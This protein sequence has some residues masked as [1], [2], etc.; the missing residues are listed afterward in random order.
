MKTSEECAEALGI[1]SWFDYQEECFATWEKEM[2]NTMCVYY[3][4]GKGKTETMLTCIAMRG[5][6]TC[7][8][9]APPI[10]HPRWVEVGAKLGIVVT[11]MSHAKFRQAE[12]KVSRFLPIIIDEFHLLGGHTGKG[13][14]KADRMAAGMQAPLIIGSATPN[15]ND[16]ERVYCIAHLLDPYSHR[17]GYLSWLFKNC[18]VEPNRFGSEPIVKGFVGLTGG[19][20]EYLSIMPHVVYLEDDAPEIITDIY[21]GYPLPVLFDEYGLDLSRV[22]LMSSDMERRHRA[23]YLQVVDPETK[24][25][26]R[27]IY[28]KLMEIAGNASKPILI[29]SDHSSIANALAAS[30]AANKVSFGYIDG[31]VSFKEKMRVVDA[32]KAGDYDVL[33]GTASLATGTDGIDKMTDEMVIL[34]DTTDTS[35]RRQLVGRVLP[36]GANPDYT[37]KI[38]HRFTYDA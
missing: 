27:H 30:L 10:T 25:V 34:D 5:F 32:Y 12:T 31:G 19:A 26:R 23:R 3:P 35:L 21:M 38:A 4:T 20:V 14:K 28:E 11:P 29:Y 13:W 16:A 6:T 17:G 7:V 15:Y 9:I 36:R 24:G 8:V 1:P 37:G 2:W 22:K 33:V 18:E